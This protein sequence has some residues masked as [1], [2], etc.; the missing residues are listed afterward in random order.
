MSRHL[1]V[2]LSYRIVSYR[3]SAAEWLQYATHSHPTV[4]KPLHSALATAE[5][6]PWPDG[7]CCPS[8]LSGVPTCF[9]MTELHACMYDVYF[10]RARSS[11][12][13]QPCTQPLHFPKMEVLCNSGLCQILSKLTFFWGIFG[14]PCPVHPWSGR[15]RRISPPWFRIRVRV[16]V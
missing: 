8:S 9:S 16:K 12:Y 1:Y 11:H 13:L 6:C 14:E 15:S 2:K 7:V 3:I 4:I 10:Q 5:W